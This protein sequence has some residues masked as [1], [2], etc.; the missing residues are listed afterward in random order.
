MP[1]AEGE[2]DPENGEWITLPTNRNYPG[3]ED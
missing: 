1:E 2:W 3:A